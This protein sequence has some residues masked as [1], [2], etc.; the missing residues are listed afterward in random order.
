MTFLN[1]RDVTAVALCAAYW[2]ILNN[3]LAPIF[4]RLTRMPFL[5]DFLAFTTLILVGWWAG[6]FGIITLTGI[7][8]TGLTFMLQPNAFQM[9]GFMVASILFDVATRL[10][11]YGNCFN[12]P[13]ISALSLL[14]LS[15]VCGW[16]AGL[17]IGSLVMNLGSILAILT[18]SGLHAVG[19]FIG[20]VIGVILVNALRA[21]ITIPTV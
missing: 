18:F 19:G 6:K 15:T 20:G 7:L 12:K 3:S 8:V 14:S 9:F 5:C 4:W 21:R 1:T 16:I 2:A 13:L 17:F 11:G 10:V